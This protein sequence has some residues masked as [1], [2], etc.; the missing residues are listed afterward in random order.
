MLYQF[1]EVLELMDAELPRVV[2]VEVKEGLIDDMPPEV[3]CVFFDLNMHFSLPAPPQRK[4]K[5][6]VDSKRYTYM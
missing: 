5:H 2:C 1:H 4:V 6:G 3:L